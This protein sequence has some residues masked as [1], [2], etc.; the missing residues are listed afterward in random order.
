MPSTGCRPIARPR[1]A[2]TVYLGGVS[3]RMWLA[4]ALRALMAI[5]FC[6]ALCGA[7]VAWWAG[8]T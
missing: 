8:L 5:V 7:L 4:E 3:R 2:G 1:A 6:L